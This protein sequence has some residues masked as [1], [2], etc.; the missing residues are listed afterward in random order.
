MMTAGLIDSM[1]MGFSCG[2]LVTAMGS[3]CHEAVHRKGDS[4]MMAFISLVGFLWF[5]VWLLDAASDYHY[6]VHHPHCASDEDVDMT[7]LHETL[8][9][10]WRAYIHKHLRFAYMFWSLVVIAIA[11]I[12]PGLASGLIATKLVLFTL[13]ETGGPYVLHFGFK[14]LAEMRNGSGK[15]VQA[16]Q[17][18]FNTCN[19]MSFAASAGLSIHSHHHIKPGQA[20]IFNAVVEDS[21]FQLRHGY[22]TMTFICI[23]AP[24]FGRQMLLRMIESEVSRL[25]WVRSAAAGSSGSAWMGSAGPDGS[26]ISAAGG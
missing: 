23:I 13:G 18:A 10:V 26:V 7:F 12:A 11:F 15:P 17:L 19:F 25:G 5:R 4:G 3:I 22:V 16:W 20:A 24:Q 1:L 14:S 2:M 6:M 9:D 8:P 21:M